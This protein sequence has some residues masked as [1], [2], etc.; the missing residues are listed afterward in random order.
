VENQSELDFV[1]VAVDMP[2]GP[3]ACLARSQCVMPRPRAGHPRSCD[4]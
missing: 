1:P 4:L 3:G 2:I